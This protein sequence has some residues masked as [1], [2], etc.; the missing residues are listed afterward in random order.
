MTTKDA[1]KKEIPA[2]DEEDVVSP[3]LELVGTWRSK[4]PLTEEDVARVQR[5]ARARLGTD[6]LF[7]RAKAVAAPP[8]GNYV[9]L[10][11]RTPLL[12]VCHAHA[13]P[14]LRV[15]FFP[16]PSL[17]PFVCVAAHVPGAR[18]W[19]APP[20]TPPVAAQLTAA[21]AA[22]KARFG[23]ARESYVCPVPRA[24]LQCDNDS[25]QN[26]DE[27]GTCDGVRVLCAIRVASA[28]MR[29][30]LPVW[31]ALPLARMRDALAPVRAAFAPPESSPLVAPFVSRHWDD[32]QQVLLQPP[33]PP[34]ATRNSDHGNSSD[35]PHEPSY[36]VRDDL[37]VVL[38]PGH[39]SGTS[40][41]AWPR[42][43]EVDLRHVQMRA[44]AVLRAFD[45][46]LAHV[47]CVRVDT[48]NT[49]TAGESAPP[50][51]VCLALT[52]RHAKALLR[53]TDAGP[54]RCVVY[55]TD[56][57]EPYAVA[58]VFD[59][60]RGTLLERLAPALASPV[61]DALAAFAQH[62]TRVAGTGPRRTAPA[63]VLTG[64][65]YTGIAER[66]RAG[67]VQRSEGSCRAV[68]AHSAAFHVKARIADDVLARAVPLFRCV[69]DMDPAAL[70][71]RY[72]PVRY[73][74]GR[75]LRSWDDIRRALEHEDE[76]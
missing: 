9:D 55:A 52:A 69:P 59:A 43:T 19:L 17:A 48:T 37:S 76:R 65:T 44:R 56:K 64:Y 40:S 14:A 7:L 46:F 49:T 34:P 5:A 21:V 12:A 75:H 41:S 13:T 18:T 66:R 54:L 32:C 15:L 11:Q 58:T 25:E 35:P 28:M 30:L 57:A 24:L 4:R 61:A 47:T 73:S 45:P 63:D 8:A 16:T 31:H 23:V 67:A 68:R 38:R 42:V 29:E 39:K 26:K 50:L 2:D 51:R 72:E 36:D 6:A 33:P 20:L 10:V 74:F 27:E 60:A 71:G 22:F 3:S 1:T 62:V 53:V 70:M